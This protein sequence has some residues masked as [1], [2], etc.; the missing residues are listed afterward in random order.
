MLG[1]WRKLGSRVRIR[2]F[3][4]T[5]RRLSAVTSVAIADDNGITDAA[6]FWLNHAVYPAFCR[7]DMESN[8]DLR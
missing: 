8:K 1:A 5:R 4:R 3:A 2:S 6:A 7:V